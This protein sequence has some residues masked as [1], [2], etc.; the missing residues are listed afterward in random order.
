MPGDGTRGDYARRLAKRSGK[1]DGRERPLGEGTRATNA[2]EIS[3][4]MHS[5]RMAEREY[6]AKTRGRPMVRGVMVNTRK[7]VTRGA[8]SRFVHEC[9]GRRQR[10]RGEDKR[11]TAYQAANKRRL[12]SGRGHS[13]EGARSANGER[14]DVATA[15]TRQLRRVTVA[16]IQAATTMQG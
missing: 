14:R 1:D 7:R 13:N 4:R 15:T 12:S 3:A 8:T 16:K 2:M 6:S 9:A 5:R 10:D 11:Y